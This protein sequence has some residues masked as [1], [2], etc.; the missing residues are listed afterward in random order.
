[1]IIAGLVVTFVLGV[2]NFYYSVQVLR[3]VSEKDGK[4]NFFELRWQVHK[5]MKKYCQLTRSETGRIGI[6]F[7]GY[8]LSLILMLVAILWLITMLS[9]SIAPPL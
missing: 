2:V 5:Q 3:R 8:W 4:M 7:Y 6:D 1:L 9:K